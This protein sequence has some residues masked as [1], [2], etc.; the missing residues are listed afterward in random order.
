MLAVFELELLTVYSCQ[1]QKAGC[2]M[3]IKWPCLKKQKAMKF[4]IEVYLYMCVNGKRCESTKQLT[5]GLLCG[6]KWYELGGDLTL[7]LF[8]STSYY[9]NI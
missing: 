8:Y 3:Y 7:S 5:H 1:V 9:E 4:M 2:R 6:W